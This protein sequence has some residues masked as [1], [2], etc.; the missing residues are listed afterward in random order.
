MRVSGNFSGSWRR[1]SAGA[2]PTTTATAAAIANQRFRTRPLKGLFPVLDLELRLLLALPVVDLQLQ[3]LGADAL[4]E[5]QAR[6]ALVIAIVRTLATEKSNQLV[7][8]HLQVAKVQ[9]VHADV[10]R[11]TV[12]RRTLVLGLL[13]YSRGDLEAVRKS[14]RKLR[15]HALG[16]VRIADDVSPTL[17]RDTIESL[18][19]L[20]ALHASAAVK[21]A[22]NDRLH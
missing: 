22:L 18:T 5:G 8:A 6:A 2:A 7:L 12:A 11:Q 16:L 10:L 21:A 14:G 19:V 15:I 3:V 20:G 17:A 4:L 13:D 9:P 1:A